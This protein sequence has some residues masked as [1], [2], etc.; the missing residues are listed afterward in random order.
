MPDAEVGSPD[1]V[2][3]LMCHR[4]EIIARWAEK[5]KNIPDTSYQP[6]TLEVIST[7][8]S[9]ELAL[10]IETL[11]AGMNHA[12]EARLKEIALTHLQAGFSINDVTSG[13]L[14]SKAIIMPIIR[15]SF[16]DGSPQ[17]F[18]SIAQLDVCLCQ[19]ISHFGHFFS[20]TMPYQLVNDARQQLAES[21]SLRRTMAVLLQKLNLDEVLEIVCT[22]ACRLTG[23]T[24]SAILLLEEGWLRVVISTG[25]PLPILERLPIVD[26]LAGLSIKQGTP[27]IVNDPINRLQAYRQ[28]P[29]VQSLLVI[30][31]STNGKNIG[32]LDVVNKLGGFT[33]DDIRIMDLFAVQ[34]AIA[35][36]NARLHQQAEQLAVLEER[37]RIARELHDSVTQSLYSA[38][39][40]TNAAQIALAKGKTDVAAEDLQEL[41]S[42][43]REAMLD[44]RLLVFELHPPILEK[45]GLIVALQARLES[46]EARSG[47]HTEFVAEGERR[48]PASIEVELY[49]IAQ[50]A[51]TNVVKHAK[52]QQVSVH[53]KVDDTCFR[54]SVWDNGR[55]FDSKNA[56]KSGGRGLLGIQERVQ[57]IGGKLM[58]DSIPGKGTTLDVVVEF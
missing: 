58:V 6:L 26:S 49:R 54:I 5:L 57:R 14:L 51:L 21:E 38:S 50:E 9:Q 43:N 10:I 24:G 19:M 48:L 18:E 3:L 40:Y 46:V 27:L 4:D 17:I 12:L 34:A 2:K 23:T 36:E 41:R 11:N 55:G 35:I 22:E 42:M 28:N 37:Q 1:L 33:K 32:V 20:E 15:S 47:I 39:L 45:E 13:L 56:G 31:L 44:M 52:A 7:W 25:T 29:D 8:L 16:P 53:L 30:P